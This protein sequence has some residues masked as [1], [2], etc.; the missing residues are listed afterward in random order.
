MSGVILDALANTVRD[1]GV[2][3]LIASAIAGVC[4]VVF[5]YH[6]LCRRDE[7]RRRSRQAFDPSSFHKNSARA[8]ATAGRPTQGGNFHG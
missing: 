4:F 1:L 2:G 8:D 7:E 5:D 6:R 3:L